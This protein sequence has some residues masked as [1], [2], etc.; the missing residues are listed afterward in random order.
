MYNELNNTRAACD[1]L[2]REKVKHECEHYTSTLVFSFWM[3]SVQPE[4]NE[5][6]S[7]SAWRP[8]R[9]FCYAMKENPSFIENLLEPSS[10]HHIFVLLYFHWWIF[11]PQGWKGE[12]TILR[13]SQWSPSQPRHCCQRKG[14][15]LRKKSINWKN[16]FALEKCLVQQ[17]KA[18]SNFLQLN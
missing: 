11:I 17:I 4:C 15:E 1:S 5:K 10:I 3:L 18:F 6:K 13:R 8:E 12:I 14:I 9:K 2:S 16:I 7:S